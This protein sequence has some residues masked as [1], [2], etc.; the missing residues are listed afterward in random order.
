MTYLHSIINPPLS[1]IKPFYFLINF[2]LLL[3]LNP[4]LFT[5]AAAVAGINSADT[6]MEAFEKDAFC[7]DIAAAPAL[8]ID[9]FNDKDADSD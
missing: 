1:S 5:G 8:K 7:E 3:P 9:A 4:P 6:R 2:H